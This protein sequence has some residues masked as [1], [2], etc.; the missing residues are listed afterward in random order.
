MMLINTYRVYN[1][2]KCIQRQNLI[3]LTGLWCHI[4][5]MC[6]WIELMQSLT[7]WESGITWQIL[8]WWTHMASWHSP[9]LS[10]SLEASLQCKQE[11]TASPHGWGCRVHPACFV[12]RLHLSQEAK[13]VNE[14]FRWNS[15]HNNT[16][17]FDFFGENLPCLL[18]LF[19]WV[20]Q[21]PLIF[22][23]L[24]MSAL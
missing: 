22:T 1:K 13:G 3:K 2:C 15:S 10:G 19:H 4:Y 24:K 7:Y 6:V 20:T 21:K 8:V 18:S 16:N 17:L 12:R 9:G 11:P 5:W 23:S 14:C